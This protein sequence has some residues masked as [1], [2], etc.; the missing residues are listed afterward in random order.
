MGHVDHGK[1]SLLDRIRSTGVARRE[2]GA[3]TQHIGASE[4]PISVIRETC[5]PTMG[6][7]KCDALKIPGL[8]FIDTPGHEA[9]TNLR[10][11]GGSVADLAVLVVDITQ[12]FQP[13]TVE[14]LKILREYK[15]PFV[16][17]ANKID[18][19]NG[20]NPQETDSF[21][22]SYASQRPEVQAAC[23]ERIYELV[24]RL[25][26]HG[27]QSERFDRIEDFRKQVP[28]VPV[29]AKTGEGIA[30]LL[31]LLA[32]IS[33]R[34]LEEQLETEV[35]GPGKGS[36]LE[37][38]DEKGLGKTIDVILY[39]GSLRKND[40]IVFGTLNGARE[41]KVRGLLKPKPLDEMRDPREK[42]DY[43]GEA[44]AATG[45]KIYAPGLDGALAG[46]SVFAV[47]P[48]NRA[49]CAEE[50]AKEISGALF[51]A[52]GPG[53]VIK[54][55]T[56]GS[57]EGLR[58]LLSAEGIPVRTAG[59][60]PVTKKDVA[61][62]NSA[63]SENRY[64]GAVLVFNVDV[65]EE[66]RA[67]AEKFKVRVLES[68]V[69]YK[70]LDDYKE[71]VQLEREAERG[72]AYS[73]MVLPAKVRI[74]PGCCFRAKSPL[75]VGVEVL[76]GRL[77]PGCKLMNSGGAEIGELKSMQ[78]DKEAVQEAKR[79]DQLAISIDTGLTFGRQINDGDV[80]YASVPKQH[81]ELLT[82]KFREHLT[83]EE[84][85][86]LVETRRVAG[87]IFLMPEAGRANGGD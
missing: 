44:H 78:K 3:I 84:H 82:G 81:Y 1:T 7:A 83:E 86:L 11:R 4:V 43:V 61:E 46:S 32:G 5:A 57:V 60:G 40:E 45:V 85:A 53:L 64:Y 62:A 31:M 25:D 76:A 34:F 37:V 13:Q 48:Q 73:S 36:I 6:K 41:T 67:E 72:E 18:L 22:K 19:M 75:I 39:D 66:A 30:E 47:T 8:L 42:F 14:A 9:F 2:A 65:L 12:G 80:L 71:W 59:I 49:K 10:K 55:D 70:L 35:K 50:I 27:F 17:A 38:K 33:Q 63:K 68:D 69:V 21:A 54:A 79:G 23:E 56:L 51:E 28:I 87:D 26:S 20:W 29:S 52:S 77:R 24:G 74:L 16:V 58:H 15:T